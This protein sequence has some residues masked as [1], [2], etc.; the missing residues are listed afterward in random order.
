MRHK[1][2]I[3]TEAPRRKERR[4]ACNFPIQT[5]RERKE[6][7]PQTKEETVTNDFVYVVKFEKRSGGEMGHTIIL[8]PA[9]AVDSAYR[10]KETARFAMRQIARSQAGYEVARAGHRPSPA[11]LN[12][13]PYYD[14]NVDSLQVLSMEGMIYRYFIDRMPIV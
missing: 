12:A 3:T 2:I 9:L 11:S 1:D 4:R 5:R 7:R 10:Q 13:I 8:G 6:P 14:E